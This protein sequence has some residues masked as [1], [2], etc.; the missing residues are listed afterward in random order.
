MSAGVLL[1]AEELSPVFNECLFGK[2][3]ATDSG[4]AGDR[5]GERAQDERGGER[6][7]E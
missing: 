7:N 4:R 6:V 5:V 1:S 2:D 3:V